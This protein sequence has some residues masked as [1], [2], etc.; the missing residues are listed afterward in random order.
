MATRRKRPAA[1]RRPA[2]PP[3]E[4][5]DDV[6]RKLERRV[7]RLEKE[8]AAEREQYERRIA[9]TKRAA[10]R[11]LAVMM[12]ELAELRHH[13]ARADALAR[14]LAE[15]DAADVVERG[16]AAAEGDVPRNPAP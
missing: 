4:S 6:I 10:D 11:R 7:K 9:A 16:P 13:E 8:H 12:R 5:K 3:R 1:A 15:R 2:P 14:M